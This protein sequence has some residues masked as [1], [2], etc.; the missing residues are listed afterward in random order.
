MKRFFGF[1]MLVAMLCVPAFAAKNSQTVNLP[2][3]VKVGSTQIPAGDYKVTWT[4]SASDTQV[5]LARNGKTVITVPAKLVAEKHNFNGVT[6]R[7]TA[8]GEIL[9]T[10]DL[11]NVSLV[12]GSEPVSGQ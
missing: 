8:S 11:G 4:G 3:T 5:S 10:I 9:Q 12:L 1:A 6:T 2:E 7:T